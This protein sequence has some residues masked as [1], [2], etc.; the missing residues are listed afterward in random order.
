VSLEGR[1][2]IPL[3]DGGKVIFPIQNADAGRSQLQPTGEINRQ[4]KPNGRKD[5]QSMPVRDHPHDSG[6][7]DDFIRKLCNAQS[8]LREGFATRK[9]VGPWRPP[10]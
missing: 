3:L 5:T 4:S 1:L 9:S 6:S 7:S 8:Q 10:E 2:K